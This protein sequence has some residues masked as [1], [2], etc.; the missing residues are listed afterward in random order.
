MKKKI[1]WLIPIALFIIGII[2]I[3]IRLIVKGSSAITFQFIW[4]NLLGIILILYPTLGKILKIEMPL[5]LEIILAIHILISV[6]LG[7]AYR[8]YDY[9]SWWDLLAHGYFG[10]EAGI[11]A[12]LILIHINGH[13]IK[14]IGKIIYF[15]VFALGLGAMWEIIEYLND[16]ITGGDCQHVY[17]VAP[18]VSPVA[19]TIED[20]MIT[21]AGVTVFSIVFIIDYFNKKKIINYMDQDFG[22][23]ENNKMD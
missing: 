14:L 4:A 15:Y 12:Y 11:I 3:L 13:D 8:I 16:S 10:L 23:I 9:I 6:N 19:D 22:Y 20:L 1:E 7:T 18:G 2:C 17:D 5:F 21:F